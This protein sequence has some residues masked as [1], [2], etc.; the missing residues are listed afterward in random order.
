MAQVYAEAAGYI[1][2]RFWPNYM[3]HG[4]MADWASSMGIA[5]ITPELLSAT[6]SEFDQNLAAMQ[7][8]LAQPE[9][10]LPLPADQVENG[11]V[12][13]A[14]IWRYWRSHGGEATFGLP[15]EPARTTDYGM[16]QT[17][18]RARLELRPELADTPF[19]VQPAP[20][21]QARLGYAR[22]VQYAISHSSNQAP[23]EQEQPHYLQK[24]VAP[25]APSVFFEETGYGM[26]EAFLNYWRRMGGVEVF[27]YPISEEFTMRTVDGQ[28][29]P[30]QYF[31]QAIFAYYPEDGSV[32]PE[33][34][35]WQQLRIEGVQQPWLHHQVR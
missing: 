9:S 25:S 19:L 31:E 3:I 13:P 27:G 12:V 30:V 20:L 7:A 21:G 33:P 24:P 10:L 2:N 8:V 6:S 22:N 29:R 11:F 32:R 26:S 16:A 5:A 23:S 1:Y 34:L 17:F 15:L 28:M 18:T 4:S 14:L 35:G